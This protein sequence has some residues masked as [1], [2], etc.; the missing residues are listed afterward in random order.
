MKLKRK[1]IAAIGSLIL[2]MLI[3]STISFGQGPPP[4][5]PGGPD[6]GDTPIGSSPAPVGSG[7]VL[8][9]L[10]VAAYTGNKLYRNF[11]TIKIKE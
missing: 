6:G 2:I 4:P 9:L 8:L 3:T 7:S 10:F 1:K 11:K 5:P